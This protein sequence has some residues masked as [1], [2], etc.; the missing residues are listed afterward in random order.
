MSATLYWCRYI[1][2]IRFIL[3]CWHLSLLTHEPNHIARANHNQ[4]T[5]G[6]TIDVVAE[7]CERIR[8]RNVS[9]IISRSTSVCVA[10][11]FRYIDSSR[12]WSI[13]LITSRMSDVPDIHLRRLPLYLRSSRNVWKSGMSAILYPLR[14]RELVLRLFNILTAW[15]EVYVTPVFF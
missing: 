4:Y 2:L 11:D 10:T 14:Y 9:C 1:L 13:D 8:V 3:I 12:S 7:L 6:E 5:H 15:L